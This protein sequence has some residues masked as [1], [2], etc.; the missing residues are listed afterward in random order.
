MHTRV[1]VFT[2]ASTHTHN[3]TYAHLHIHINTSLFHLHLSFSNLRASHTV[4][5]ERTN[6]II[7]DETRNLVDLEDVSHDSVECR[8]DAN[9][10]N[11]EQKANPEKPPLTRLTI[12][13]NAYEFGK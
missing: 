2:Y 7:D 13:L 8:E 4:T 5:F 6:G 11:L 12:R 1:H 10:D 9:E 3:Y